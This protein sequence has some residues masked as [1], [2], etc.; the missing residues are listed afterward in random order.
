LVSA[1]ARSTK[2][3]MLPEAEAAEDVQ[4]TMALITVSAWAVM[5]GG[6]LYVGRLP[7]SAG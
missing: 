4:W 3:L 7:Y 6:I 2:A 5:V 1:I